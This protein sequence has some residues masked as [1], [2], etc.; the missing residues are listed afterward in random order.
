MSAGL[1]F[2]ESFT[3]ES[4]LIDI[5][6]MFLKPSIVLLHSQRS[7][8]LDACESFRRAPALAA[9]QFARFR[10]LKRVPDAQ[11]SNLHDALEKFN[12]CIRRGPIHLTFSKLQKSFCTHSDLVFANWHIRL[13]RQGTRCFLSLSS[14]VSF[15]FDLFS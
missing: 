3:S 7:T 11:R 14:Q 12:S 13:V 15:S 6:L 1:K 10:S 2:F 8:T 9:I 4:R 5:R